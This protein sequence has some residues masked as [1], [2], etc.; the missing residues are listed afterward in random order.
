MSVKKKYNNI[1][2]FIQIQYLIYIV[3]YLFSD[4]T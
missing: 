3:I 2:Y 1:L 4:L